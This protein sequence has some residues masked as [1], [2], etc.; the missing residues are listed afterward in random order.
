MSQV[1][2]AERDAAKKL[3]KSKQGKDQLKEIKKRAKTF[4]PGDPL[5]NGSGARTGTNAAGLTPEQVLFAS[6]N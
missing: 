4:N 6:R 2:D 3:Y 5:E 1:K